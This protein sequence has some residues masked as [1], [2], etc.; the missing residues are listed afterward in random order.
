[1]APFTRSMNRSTPP[2]YKPPIILTL[3]NELL[4][5]IARHA[6]PS[7]RTLHALTLTCRALY[8]FIDP[9]LYELDAKNQRCGT[10]RG[11]SKAIKHAIKVPSIRILKHALAAGASVRSM[12]DRSTSGFWLALET[13]A[14][15]VNGEKRRVQ[16]LDEIIM[17]MVAD[18]DADVN[19]RLECRCGYKHEFGPCGWQPLT[20]AVVYGMEELA[21]ILIRKGAHVHMGAVL[22]AICKR[23]R[24]GERLRK[25]KECVEPVEMAVR[26]GGDVNSQGENGE[27]LLHLL[28]WWGSDPAE[29]GWIGEVLRFLI[30]LGADINAMDRQGQTPLS[31]AMVRLGRELG[32]GGRAISST[33]R[34]KLSM[35]RLLLEHGADAAL[36]R[37]RMHDRD[38]IYML[39]RVRR[40][41]SK[42][43]GRKIESLEH[44]FLF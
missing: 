31:R 40:D 19:E 20:Y 35:M 26:L 16:L 22:E 1:M 4:L 21:E 3:P 13:R 41:V 34:Q 18:G 9:L 6:G 38:V 27:T 23:L 15:I 36:M 12:D 43:M 33:T 44:C 24:W 11:T 17:F 25:G 32:Y 29:T 14:A 39:G 5:E 30:G 37:E 10:I 2:P 28:A 8:S 7:L 42:S